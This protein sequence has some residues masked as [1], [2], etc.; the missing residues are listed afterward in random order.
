MRFTAYKFTLR[1]LN[2]GRQVTEEFKKYFFHLYRVQ[3]QVELNILFR[4]T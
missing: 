4:V 3:N 1:V 2:F